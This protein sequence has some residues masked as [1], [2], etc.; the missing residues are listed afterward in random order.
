MNILTA[1]NKYSILVLCMVLGLILGTGVPHQVRK[2]FAE[3][4]GISRG[5]V[6]T[7]SKIDGA[8][9][10]IAAAVKPAVVNVST[11]RTIKT[12]GIPNPFSADPFFRQ[13]FG[14][15]FGNAH[16]PREYKQASLGSGVIVDKD[17]YILTNNHVVK[18]AD[19]IKIKLSDGREFKGKVI[20]TDPK[21]DLAVIKIGSDHLPVV[22]W[23][24][25][26]RLRVG[27]RVLAFGNPYGLSQT[28][29]SGIVSATGRANVG[30]ADYE[31][32]I[33]TD[34]P[35]NPGNSGGALISIR[36]ELIG[37]NTAI[38]S[39]S[40]G[41]QGIGF[42]IPSNMAKS[43]M[44]SLIKRG[45]V[46]R[47]WLGLSIQPIT[48]E[49]A[50]QFG[51]K[52]EKGALVGDVVEGSPAERAG[53][54]RG[55]VVVEFDGKEVRDPAGLRNMAAN[56]PPGKEVTLKVLREGKPKAIKVTIAELPADMQKVSGSYE[57]LLKG[58]HVQNIA[59]ELRGALGI[60]K[61]VTGVVVTDVDEGNP[62]ETAL[63]KNDVIMEINKRRI[64]N[65]K[66]FE[67]A[68]SQIKSNQ[69][70]LLL[71]YRNGSAIYLT[72]SAK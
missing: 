20:G 68:A 52:D 3:Q 24:D 32:F 12:P 57:N 44:D 15:A 8:M 9:A 5:A 38:F 29:T 72:L 28:V 10:E 18:D 69:N 1:R 42:A 34:A 22:K 41:Y 39:T 65:S 54:Q 67:T 62:A 66:D 70:I 14:D 6:D 50:G 45:K 27:E 60:P 56:T 55:D 43:V 31:D 64:N 33:Q 13:F 61:R 17:G 58:V 19:E 46:V 37:I 63:M 7:L 23:G 40:G 4:K 59:P 51:L 26:D 71:I 21:T 36:G 35:I 25:S 47:G 11:T 2:V 53:L 49:L 30:I 48:P 16:G